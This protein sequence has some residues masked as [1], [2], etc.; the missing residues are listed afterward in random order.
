M[1]IQE[2]YK[3]DILPKLKK[4]F[5]F[6]ND[7]EVPRLEKVV[8]NVGFGKHIKDNEY[9]KNLEESLVKITGQKPV[10]TKA[11]KSISSFKIREGMVIGA[12]LT[13][14]KKRMYDFVEKLL[15]VTFPRVRDFQGISEKSVDRQGNLTIGFKDN[16]AF[17]EIGAQDLDKTHGME[18]ILKTTAKSREEGLELFRLLK[19][20]FKEQMKEMQKEK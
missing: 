5:G 6:K 20:P 11:R 2:F 10:F 3:K 16:L 18:I 14:R 1:S 8:I 7:R 19:F 15:S 12:K 4:D 9:I 17:P 13:L